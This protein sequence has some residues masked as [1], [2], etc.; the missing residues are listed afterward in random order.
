MEWNPGD[1]ATV[2][3]IIG[4]VILLLFAIIKMVGQR[5][6][7]Q[8]VA[9]LQ[10]SMDGFKSMQNA[11]DNH[12][13]GFASMSS[14]IQSSFQA[15]LARVEMSEAQHLK[16]STQLIEVFRSFT[17]SVKTEHNIH[18]DEIL[19]IVPKITELTQAQNKN[20]E[21]SEGFKTVIDNALT[22]QNKTNDEILKALQRVEQ[23]QDRIQS[24]FQELLDSNRRNEKLM[25]ELMEKPR[26]DINAVKADLI[27][28]PLVEDPKLT[29]PKV[30]D[31]T[32]ETQDE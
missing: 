11:L 12:A 9:L 3:S 18:S 32:K 7:P 21:Q 29:E 20:H 5:T 27:I 28:N 13:K 25:Q 22:S 24:V 26:Q 8:L 2:G 1:T 4:G 16:E 10:Q 31:E 30:K 23:G 6:D 17:T 14:G 19:K 15:I